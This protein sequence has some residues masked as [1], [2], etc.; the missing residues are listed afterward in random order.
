MLKLVEYNPRSLSTVFLSST[1]QADVIILG[2]INPKEIPA[3]G[4][5]N[6]ISS[7]LEK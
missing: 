2:N 3:R 4:V 5:I 1:S 7:A 6:H